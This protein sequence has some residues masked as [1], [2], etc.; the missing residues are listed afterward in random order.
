MCPSASSRRG[1]DQR[2][3]DRGGGV[4]VVD[5]SPTCARPRPA[6]DGAQGS[7]FILGLGNVSG[8]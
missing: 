7:V 5:D 4:V 3:S 8:P 1:Y 6:K 2:R